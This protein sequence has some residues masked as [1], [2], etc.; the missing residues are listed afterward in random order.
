MEAHEAMERV[1]RMHGGGHG[2][3]DHGDRSLAAPAAV[4]VA[5]LAAFLAVAT[6]LANEQVKDVINGQTKASETGGQLEANDV[7]TTVADANAVLLRVV[8]TG[9]PKEARAVAKAE[10]LER[11]IDTELRPRDAVLQAK[12]TA[13]FKEGTHSDNKHTLYEIA[14]VGLQIGIVLAGISILA[15]RRWLLGFGGLMGAAG[16]GVMFAGIAY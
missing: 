6:F 11:R 13:D 16:M 5:I 2:H 8:G 3:G 4:T 14:E 12:V 9:N 15:R 7:K 10:Q 1:E